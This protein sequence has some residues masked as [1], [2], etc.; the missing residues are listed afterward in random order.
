M[1][2]KPLSFP[3]LATVGLLGLAACGPSTTTSSLSTPPISDSNTDT[4][5]ITSLDSPLGPSLAELRTGV[6]LRGV[7]DETQVWPSNDGSVTNTRN[8]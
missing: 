7:I 1:K 8:A 3:L 6:A 2:S 4:L 5:A